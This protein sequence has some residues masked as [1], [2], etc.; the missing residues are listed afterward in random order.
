MARNAVDVKLGKLGKRERE[1]SGVGGGLTRPSGRAFFEKRGDSFASDVRRPRAAMFE[2]TGADFGVSREQRGVEKAFGDRERARFVRKKAVDGGGEGRVEVVGFD[3]R[4]NEPNFD[5]A[6]GGEGRGG[7]N[8]FLKRG[9]RVFS[10]QKREEKTRRKAAFRFGEDGA[11]SR[12]GDDEIANGNEP[13]AAPA[14][15]AANRR[16]DRFRR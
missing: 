1:E 3:E 5:G 6:S 15:R 11:E 9:E 16:D 4:L 7:Q 13:G 12:V 14:S 8:E 2:P 10:A